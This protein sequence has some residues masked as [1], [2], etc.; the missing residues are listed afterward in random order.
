[1]FA[2]C[3]Y[4]CWFR[5]LYKAFRSDSSLH[6]FSFF[7]IFMVQFI[8]SVINAIGFVGYGAVGWINSLATIGTSLGVGVFMLICA[9]M[10]TA[11][12]TL[13]FIFLVSVHRLYRTTGASF[14]QARSE[15]A[16]SV[17]TSQAAQAAVV[18]AATAGVSSAPPG[19][20]RF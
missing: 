8:V 18:Q 11:L 3:S 14:E 9:S 5:P 4:V 7:L 20:R 16:A 13:D 12:A 1:M 17:L 2:P 19:S 10:F 6:F 15:L